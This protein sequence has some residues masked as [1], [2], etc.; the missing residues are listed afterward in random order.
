MAH[1]ATKKYTYLAQAGILTGLTIGG[2]LLGGLCSS[3]IIISKTG[4]NG[5]MNM[6]S[7]LIPENAN[8]LRVVQCVGVFFLF[9]VPAFLY[10]RIC[11]RMAL[12]HLGMSRNIDLIQLI[13]SVLF[14]FSAIPLVAALREFTLQL[15]LG[16]VIKAR[17][18]TSKA[19]FMKQVMVL[20]A[21]RSTAEYFLALF[22]MAILPG[23]CEEIFF[24]GAIQNL[25]TRWFKNPVAAILLAAFIF[26]IFHFEYADFIGRFFLGIV[27]GWVFYQTGNLW[28]TVVMHAAFNALSV[29]A[30]YLA[31][32]TGV[33][34]DPAALDDKFNLMLT[35]ISAAVFLIIGL[36]F[37]IHNKKKNN[38]PGKEVLP[39]NYEDPDNPSWLQTGTTEKRP[40]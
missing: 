27:L 9:L 10:A 7:L 3:F 12:Q 4:I 33:K 39:D 16:E 17:I 18:L 25:F 11:H 28:L 1:I 26:S 29:T 40:G 2:L 8:L 34:P 15:P 13:L 6:D 20:G 23:I 22:I 19:E 24:R 32:R 35:L 37:Y 36:L 5:A 30:L 21:M 31:S 14:I 38:M